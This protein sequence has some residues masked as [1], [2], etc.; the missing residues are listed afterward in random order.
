MDKRLEILIHFDYKYIINYSSIEEQKKLI[1]EQSIN[2]NYILEPSKELQLYFINKNPINIGHI[3]NS[4]N[5][6]QMISVKYDCSV[7]ECILH[8]SI[9]VQD[10][11]LSKNIYYLD[12]IHNIHFDI[13][14]KY[15]TLIVNK[16]LT[17]YYAKYTVDQLIELK[18]L[19]S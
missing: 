16:K 1:D 10:Y 6:A 5:E 18:L 9:E 17:V 3:R 7:I 13:I 15:Y 12:D 8:P 4:C 11:V 14:K 2:M 19:S